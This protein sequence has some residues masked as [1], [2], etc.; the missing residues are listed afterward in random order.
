V[1]RMFGSSDGA[2]Q[3]LMA[4]ANI[5]ECARPLPLLAEKRATCS[6]SVPTQTRLVQAKTLTTARS[7]C[8]FTT[9]IVPFLC[10]Y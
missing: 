5:A 8:G 3:A 1:D 4:S 6:L 2:N 10:L 7:G 9:Q